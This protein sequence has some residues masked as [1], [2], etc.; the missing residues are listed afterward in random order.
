MNGKLQPFNCS[1]Q[2]FSSMKNSLWICWGDSPSFQPPP[3]SFLILLIENWKDHA[4][5]KNMLQ[6]YL[7]IFFLNT[8][9]GLLPT[10]QP[11][12][13]FPL[14]LLGPSLSLSLLSVFINYLTQHLPDF[15]LQFMSRI[16]F[17]SDFILFP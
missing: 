4:S 17:L 11:F 12:L 16:I 15:M 7:Y 10:N 5:H 2:M 1:L 13:Y 6:R 9:R 3:L 14:S 8:A